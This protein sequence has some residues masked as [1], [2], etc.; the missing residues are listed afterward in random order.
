MKKFLKPEMEYI[1]FHAQDIITTSGDTY[2]MAQ[3]QY[4]ETTAEAKDSKD[5]K[6]LQDALWN[7]VDENINLDLIGKD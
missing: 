6:A 5:Y 3:N 7:L 2:D 1:A 4:V